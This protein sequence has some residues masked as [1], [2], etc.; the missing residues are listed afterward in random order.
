M[1]DTFAK[2][3]ALLDDITNR[4]STT[5]AYQRGRLSERAKIVAWLRKEAI[6]STDSVRRRM[7]EALDQVEAGE[8]LK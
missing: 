3:L 5:D 4:I 6:F 1:T 2:T 7:N 8:H